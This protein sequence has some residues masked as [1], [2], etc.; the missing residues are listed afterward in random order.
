MTGSVCW[1][2]PQPLCPPHPPSF[3]ILVSPV[4]PRDIGRGWACTSSHPTIK[5]MPEFK[6][7]SPELEPNSP[8]CSYGPTYMPYPPFCV[9]GWRW[10][11]SGQKPLTAPRSLSPGA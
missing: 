6:V 11:V 9:G 5:G 4:L 3:P 8:E 2:P 10:R 7:T 1:W